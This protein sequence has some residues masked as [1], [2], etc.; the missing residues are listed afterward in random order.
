MDLVFDKVSYQPSEEITGIAP[1]AGLIT[2]SQLGIPISDFGCT[3]K[4]NLGVFPEGAYS[5]TWKTASKPALTSAFEVLEQPWTRLR[6]GFVTE[7]SDSVVTENYVMWAKKLHLSAIQFYDW[8]WRHEFLTTEKLHYGDSLG[9]DISTKKIKELISSYKEIGSTSCGYAAIYAVDAE[10]WER[11][12]KA[13]LF[14]IEGNPYL[15]GDN[16]LWIL[17][18]ADPTW[19]AHMISQLQK[20]HEFGFTAFHLDQYGW[21]KNALN[22][23][24][25]AV[26][27]AE[28][29]PQMLDEIVKSLPECKHI[30]NNVN[31]YPTWS[32]T[33]TD[34]H[35]T[36]IEV[37]DPHTTYNHLA[38]LVAKARELA[39]VKP[40]ILSAYLHPFGNIGKGVSEAEAVASFELTFASIVSGGASHL[41]TGGDGRVLHHAYYVNNYVAPESTLQTIQNYYDLAVA[42]GDLL[43]DPTRVDV[44]LTNAFGVN[45]EIKFSSLFSVSSEATPGHLWIRVY[46]GQTGLTFHVINLLDQEDTIWDKPKT[47]ISTEAELTISIEAAGFS[48][49]ASIGRSS[50]GADFEVKPMDIHGNRLDVI[51]DVRAAWTIINIPYAARD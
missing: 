26:D 50:D 20:A 38:G 34:Q 7:F 35:A 46:T 40:V 16:F 37:W 29:F 27:L 8:A 21:P 19:L 39:P 5:I 51:I 9:Q 36:Y 49:Q 14:D 3:D 48:G 10:G 17:D 23:E 28:R 45:N 12:R 25:G 22:S 4:F 13:G 1:Q 11:W 32:T 44:T 2:V 15:L 47:E 43:Y 42:A 6:Y 41:I 24:G 31:D 18:P 30:F 33:Q